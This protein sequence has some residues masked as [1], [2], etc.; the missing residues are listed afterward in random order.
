MQNSVTFDIRGIGL[1]KRRSKDEEYS[2]ILRNL[3]LIVHSGERLALVG[4][5]GSGKTTL[6]RLLASLEPFSE[7][8]I[9]FEGKHI[10]EL[11]PRNYRKTVGFVR[12]TS[13][14]FD[15]TIEDN[16]RFAME[17][18]GAGFE[19][20][21]AEKLLAKVGLD[22]KLLCAKS[23]TLSVGQ[24]QRVSIARTLATEPQVLLMD[25]PTSAL[26]PHSAN[27]IVQLVEN[28]ARE[29]N[30]TAILVLHNLEL[31][32]KGTDRIALL[33]C[34]KIDSFAPTADF[35][36]NPPTELARRFVNGELIDE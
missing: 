15:G 30:I 21:K 33:H 20:E 8:E 23:D 10:E 31:A 24:A 9:L 32:K 6:L 26:D 28:L 7:G 17:V 3:D 4:N 11:E 1:K 36:A 22:S 25:E 18:S 5:S 19:R 13:A 27:A 14:M 2:W 35:F 12:Q 16:L 34:G 29:M